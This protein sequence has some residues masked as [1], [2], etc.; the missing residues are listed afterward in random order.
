MHGVLKVRPVASPH[1]GS[2]CFG[3]ERDR[4]WRMFLQAVPRPSSVA[5][6]NRR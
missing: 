1:R 2:P 5:A 6:N 4:R 3:V